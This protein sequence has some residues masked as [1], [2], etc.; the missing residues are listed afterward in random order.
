MR[1]LLGFNASTIYEKHNL[2]PNTVNILPVD[3]VFLETDIAQGM[4]FEGNWTGRKQNFTMDVDPGCKSHAG[5]CGRVQWYMIET[6]DSISN[7][8]FKVNEIGILISFNGQSKTFRLLFKE[9]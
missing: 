5:F 9:V 3:V 7:V 6:K 2:S 8:A 1:D 4:I